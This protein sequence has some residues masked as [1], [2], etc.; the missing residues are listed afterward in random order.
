MSYAEAYKELVKSNYYAYVH[1]VH[2]GLWKPSKAGKF[3]TDEV[4]KFIEEDTGNAF[5]ILIVSMPPQHGKS[6]TITETLPSWYLGRNPTHRVIEV[7]YSEEFAKKFGRRNKQKIQ[8]HG[9]KLFGIKLAEYPN[10]SIEF[11]LSNNVGGMISRG[12]SSGVTG[13]PAN[14]IIIDDPVKNAQEA[15][16]VTFRNNVWSEWQQSIRTRLAAK[17]K[18]IVIMTRW[19]EDDLAGRLIKEEKN[20]RVIN[21]PC[22]CESEDDLLGRDLGESLMPEIGKDDNWL[23]DFK[24]GYMTKHGSIAWNALFQGR[25]STMQG[26]MIKREWWK[27]YD[28]LP[29]CPKWIMSVD[30]AFKDADDSDFVAIQVWAKSGVNHYLVERLKKHLDFTET[31]NA[32]KAFKEK[33]PKIRGIYVEDK[34]NGSAVI[35]VL[36]K[37][38]P[39]VIAVNPEGG[40]VARVNAVSPL[41]EAGNVWLPLYADTEEFVNECAVFPNGAHDDE[42]DAMSQ[43]LNKLSNYQADL[44]EPPKPRGTFYNVFNKPV[45]KIGKGEK[46]HVI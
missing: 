33:Y 28:V 40:K 37:T 31:V 11:E 16:S 29:N 15:N 6:M 46:I 35:S 7:S 18:V 13:Q 24:Q 32:V 19:H 8:D 2:D 12:I 34:A 30:A 9:E 21:L 4:Q 26:N 43:A 44:P 17:S 39:G 14:L 38:I 1:Y 41:I 3:L 22:E 36:R 23:I 42:V 10:S 5:D 27:Y 20:V 45:T 25:P